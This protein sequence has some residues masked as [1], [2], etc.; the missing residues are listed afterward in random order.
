LGALALA[1]CGRFGQRDLTVIVISLDTT[2]PDHLT[3]YA[4]E[5]GTTPALDRLARQG[6]RFTAA[7]STAP[8]TLP[9]HM[10][11]FTGLPPGLHNV[12]IDF[13]VLDQGRRTMGEMFHDAG[14]RTMG[15]FTAPYVHGR[16]G[17]DRGMDFY[18]RATLEPM[19]WDLPPESM[20]EQMKTREFLSHLEVTSRQLQ[21]RAL[22]LLSN[23]TREKNLLFLHYFDP[24][25]D[26]LAPPPYVKRFANPDYRGPITGKGI[27]VN[28]AIKP[29][30]SAA[31]RAQLEALYDA[32]LAF[33]DETIGA[34]LAQLERQDRLDSTL[35]VVTADHGEAFFEHGRFGH[36]RD[37]T[38]EVLKVP[39]IIWGPGLGIAAGRVVDESVSLVDVLPTLLDY[40]GLPAESQLD[41]RSL[42]PLIEGGHWTERPA[43][44]ALSFF[45][46]DPE[47]YYELHESLILGTLK[48]VRTLHVAWTPE[49][50]HDLA[51]QVVPGS[52][53][54][55]VFD[56][57]A[58]PGETRNL[59]GTDDPRVAPLLQAFHSERNRQRASLAAFR[60][61]GSAA[62]ALEVPLKEILWA[63]GY[64]IGDAASEDR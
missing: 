57:A 17:F 35:I 25:S 1:G 24:H 36:R 46:A 2:R 7:R 11:L 58:D 13:Q 39:L 22:H 29:D 38:D 43:T 5:R 55:Q 63:T 20:S 4:P 8:W 47:G 52:E 14:Y 61:K 23:S 49:D 9:A 59:H 18:E 60:P 51:G 45:P 31:D 62:P 15:V 6:T 54:V 53:V 64:L 48:V 40:A 19:L 30:M 34:L 42:R 3:P 41:G 10:T 28:P 37:L 26:Y 21:E 50:E 12:N 56:L 16:F 27:L 33:V 32:E 44:A